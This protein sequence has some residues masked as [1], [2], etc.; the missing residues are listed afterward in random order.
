MYACLVTVAGMLIRH[1]TKRL[2]SWERYDIRMLDGVQH[3]L[4]LCIGL[5]LPVRRPQTSKAAECG[6]LARLDFFLTL[7]SEFKLHHAMYVLVKSLAW[8]ME[9]GANDAKEDGEWMGGKRTT[10]QS[11]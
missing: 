8:G 6:S 9:G 5:I 11:T 3:S 1:L 2:I 7:T 4:V 10:N